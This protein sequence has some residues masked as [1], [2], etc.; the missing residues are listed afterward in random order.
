V[1]A[2]AA[3]WLPQLL[4]AGDVVGVAWGATLRATAAAL[5]PIGLGAPVV[6]ICGAVPGLDSGT[7]PSEV[8]FRVA[9]R[10]G[11]AL[12]VLPAPALTGPLA[13]AEL[14]R[15]DAVSPTIGLFERVTAALV[16][17]GVAPR[18]AAA[19]AA[20]H[21]LVY[22]FDDTGRVLPSDLEAIALSLDQLRRA[23]VIAIAGGEEKRRAVLGALRSGLLD[24]LVT[25]EAVARYAVAG[26]A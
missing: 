13:R 5:E 11:G 19:G 8:A 7:G 15:N 9:E 18:D 20:G 16:G 1:P 25:D 24:V 10:L 21:I 12:H 2:R 14:L 22:V 4:G 17:I 6:Q 3:A 23:R 26:G